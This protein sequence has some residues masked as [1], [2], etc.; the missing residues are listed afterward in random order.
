[1]DVKFNNGYKFQILDTIFEV[2]IFLTDELT[3]NPCIL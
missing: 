1:M 2:G 3:L